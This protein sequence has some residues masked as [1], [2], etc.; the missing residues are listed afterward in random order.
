VY[1]KSLSAEQFHT[2]VANT[3]RRTRSGR[4]RATASATTA[5]AA[6]LRFGDWLTGDHAWFTARPA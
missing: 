3:S 1:E 5:P 2:P 6:N 4:W